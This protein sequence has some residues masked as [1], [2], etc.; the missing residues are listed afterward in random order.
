MMQEDAAKRRIEELR[1]V[2]EHHLYQYHV[3]DNPE[4]AD[5]EYDKLLHELMDLEEAY[6]QYFDENSPTV[7][8]GG[9]ISNS[10]APVAHIVQMGSLQDVF[11]VEALREFDRKV[12][13][14][15][16]EP[17]YVGEP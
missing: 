14:V 1:P 16:D 12:R 13:A 5:Y 17:L 8:V 6:P 15:V 4:I 7:R 3:L 11:A 2:L 9:K 10:F